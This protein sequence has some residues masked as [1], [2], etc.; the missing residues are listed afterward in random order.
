MLRLH[1]SNVLDVLRSH[2]MALATFTTFFGKG[3]DWQSSIKLQY[4]TIFCLTELHLRKTS[5]N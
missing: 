3:N 5:Q 1:V 4:C 2:Q